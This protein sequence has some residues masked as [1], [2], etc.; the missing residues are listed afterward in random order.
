MRF[1]DISYIYATIINKRY[2]IF[3]SK[4]YNYIDRAEQGMLLRH[5]VLLIFLGM[6][7]S[8][9]PKRDVTQSFQYFCLF[10]TL[11]DHFSRCLSYQHLKTSNLVT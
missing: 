5:E 9:Y 11:T 1:I 10:L 6:E 7:A 4:N 2:K 3:Y 8:R